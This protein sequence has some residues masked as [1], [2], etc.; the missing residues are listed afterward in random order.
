MAIVEIK[1]MK[2]QPQSI[3]VKAGE[4]VTWRNRDSMSHTATDDEGGWDTGDIKAQ[5]DASIPFPKPGTYPYHCEYH[6]R[7]VGVVVVK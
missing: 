2:Y 5:Q 4:L 1:G 6:P 3:E 7:M